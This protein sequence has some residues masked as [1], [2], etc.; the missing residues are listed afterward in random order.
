[1]N[2]CDL[3]TNETAVIKNINLND[4]KRV[5]LNDLGFIKGEYITNVF[6]YIFDNLV[7]YKVK[8]SFIALRKEDA[9][10]IEVEYE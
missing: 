10:F 3:K 7:C 1:M 9:Y 6:S 8:N 2:L 4:I 5:R